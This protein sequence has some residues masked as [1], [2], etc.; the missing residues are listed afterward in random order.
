MQDHEEMRSIMDAVNEMADELGLPP[1]EAPEPISVL[2]AEWSEPPMRR[3]AC[4]NEY[5]Y[6]CESCRAMQQEASRGY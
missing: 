6:E 5:Q 2:P 1:L 4:G 3:C